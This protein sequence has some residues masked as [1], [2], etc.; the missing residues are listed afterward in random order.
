VILDGETLTPEAVTGVARGGFPVVLSPEGRKRNE[1][2]YR[3]TLKL[4]EGDA[5]VYGMNTGVGALRT[6]S[7][8]PELQEDHQLRL[9]R[10]HAVGAGDRVPPEISRA[11]LAVR[12]N[13]IAGGGAGVHPELLDALVNVLNAGL[14]PEIRELGSLG[15][16][17]L[18]SLAEAG[19]TLIGDRPFADGRRRS[20]VPLGPRDGLMLMGSNAHAISEAA[21]CS[22]DLRR[23]I[24]TSE[25]CAA[26][27]FEAVGANP[28]ALDARVHAARP[29]P[30]QV[31]AAERLRGLL[32]GYDSPFQRLQDSYAF[33]CLPQV[34]G[35]L[36]DVHE[37]LERVLRVEMNSATE[38]SLLFG[39]EA[40]TTGNFHAAPLAVALDHTRNAISQA[41]SLSAARLSALM[42]PE[43]SGLS[44]FLA[45]NPGPDSGLMTFEYTVN[46]A[47]GELRL[48][49]TPA[50]SQ[51]AVF[52]SQGVENHASFASL[53]AR[54]TT[55]AVGLLAS[56]V[57][58]E[59]VAAV[60]A[61]RMHGALPTGRGV[62][63]AFDAAAAKLPAGFHDRPLTEDL[64]TAT[65]LV[66]RE[67]LP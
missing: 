47:A 13:Q 29:H 9:L 35:V 34:A 40:L 64:D 31:A 51:S 19:L 54:Q 23:L 32:D 16:S 46:S 61:F 21:L 55:R 60:R 1:A 27:A 38:N 17:D 14:A 4:I 24:L 67:G 11:M 37:H 50:A 44:P 63:E 36:R 8:S 49:A 28:T 12:G 25:T 2:A 18:T 6:V 66:L 56:I 48:L 57:G 59:L 41:A 7:I 65:D 15:T 53:A 20:P 5:P 52:I 3:T 42:N 10:S 22:A 58:A 39:G 62:K 30:G 26:I 43:T 33:R 45:E